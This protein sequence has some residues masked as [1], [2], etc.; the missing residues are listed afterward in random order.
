MFRV[1]RWSELRPGGGRQQEPRRGP[2]GLEDEFTEAGGASRGASHALCLHCPGPRLVFSMISSVWVLTQAL[3]ST[4][5]Q[6]T[7]T[8]RV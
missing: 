8:V 7:C 4:G 1:L 3:E 6:T 5:V 2:P